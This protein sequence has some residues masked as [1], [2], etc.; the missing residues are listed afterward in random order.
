[1]IFPAVKRIERNL[2]TQTTPLFAVN[3]N[4]EAAE[5]MQFMLEFPRCILY[6]KEVNILIKTT[7]ILQIV[8]VTQMKKISIIILCIA[9]MMTL[10]PTSAYAYTYGLHNYS[11][12][13][14]A[15]LKTF[16]SAL[17]DDGV[18]TNGEQLGASYNPDDPETWGVSW[19]ADAVRTAYKVDWSDHKDIKG[20]LNVS[21][22][23]DL[24]VVDINNT[25]VTSLDVS[26]DSKIEDIN[27]MGTA[28]TQLSVSGHEALAFLFASDCPSLTSLDASGCIGL[29][30]LYASNCKLDTLDLTGCTLL[31]SLSVDKNKLTSLD[32]S[33]YGSLS[34]LY[35]QGNPELAFLNVEDASSLDDINCSEC[36]LP[37]LDASGLTK[38]R[39]LDCGKNKIETLDI[40]GD[41]TLKYL[42]CS[43][44][45]IGTL[46]LTG[47]TALENIDCNKNK[48]QSLS[49]AGMTKLETLNCSGNK[50]AAIA[51]LS[52]TALQY[53]DCGDNAITALNLKGLSSLS[54]LSCY[55][56][57]LAS[58]DVSDNKDLFMFMCSDN[59]IASLDLSDN[60]SLM[61]LVCGNNLL[62][63]LD[64]S[65]SVGLVYLDTTGNRLASVK[66][67]FAGKP[68]SLSAKGAGYVE[69]CN[70]PGGKTADFYANAVPRSGETFI[71]WTASGAQVSKSAK[72]GLAA[73]T[74]YTL[75]AN[76]TQLAFTD[77]PSGSIY[78]GGRLTLTPNHEGGTWDFDTAY[79]SREGN[80]FTGLKAGK[81]QITYTWGD[82]TATFDVTI[83]AASLPQTGQDFTFVYLLTAG[84]AVMAIAALIIARRKKANAGR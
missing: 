51:G 21:G 70:I 82:Q 28:L 67:V 76:F 7:K 9:L 84:A 78:T 73:D 64:V 48:I 18:K 4:E 35:C 56:N 54:V 69:L 3:I 81:T 66:A 55:K 17:S 44:N 42:T 59:K 53:L 80:T 12:I 25:S 43:E 39:I 26:G 11:D 58:L 22:F 45:K 77:P 57:Q 31:E 33:G 1:M 83:T 52:D 6:A 46:T 29:K 30:K 2:R 10:L 38:L 75:V 40:T 74:A 36:A 8:Q 15:R 41:T 63:S 49:V 50:L 14:I 61:Y 34:S 24:M 16:L 47:F 72:Y 19:K 60:K 62:T 20:A 5:N 23:A 71:H 65:G 13:E 79:L 32:V 27:C 37:A 68:V